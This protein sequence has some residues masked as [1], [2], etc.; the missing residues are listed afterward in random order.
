M[1]TIMAAKLKHNRCL[2]C[3]RGGWIMFLAQTEQPMKRLD[4]SHQQGVF[5]HRSA[6]FCVHPVACCVWKPQEIIIWLFRYR[7]RTWVHMLVSKGFYVLHCFRLVHYNG[8]CRH[9]TRSVCR[10]SPKWTTFTIY[11][12]RLAKLL[13]ENWTKLQTACAIIDK[14]YEGKKTPT[15]TKEANVGKHVLSTRT[16]LQD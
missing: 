9:F 15:D 1:L 12:R 14:D 13:L 8:K 11:V 6:P 7:W 3:N 4:L 5:A 16:L 2:V 10:S